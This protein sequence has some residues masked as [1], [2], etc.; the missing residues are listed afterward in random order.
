MFAKGYAPNLPLRPC[1]E[2]VPQLYTLTN[3]KIPV[4]GIKYVPSEQ[5]NLRIMTP[6]YVC[7]VKPHPQCIKTNLIE[8]LDWT[9][10][11]DTA[12]SH[13]DNNKHSI[14]DTQ[15]FSTYEQKRS[16]YLQDTT[17]TQ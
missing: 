15:D 3:K 12:L 5:D 14:F 6:Y 4:Y 1:G 8:D 10:T 16:T 2:S 9:S 13:M 17:S 11:R 7:D